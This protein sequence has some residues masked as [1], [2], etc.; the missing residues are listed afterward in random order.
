[1]GPRNTISLSNARADISHLVSENRDLTAQ[2]RELTTQVSDIRADAMRYRNEAV[3][4]E[5]QLDNSP[6][7]SPKENA[8]EPN[9]ATPASRGMRP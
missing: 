2:N 5:A 6:S 9:A 3:S 4:L 1:M 7:A 8:P